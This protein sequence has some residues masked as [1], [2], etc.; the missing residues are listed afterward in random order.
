MAISP[1]S[2]WCIRSGRGPVA[3][4]CFLGP[5][6]TPESEHSGPSWAFQ[7]SDWPPLRGHIFHLASQSTEMRSVLD[8]FATAQSICGGSLQSVQLNGAHS[9]HSSCW[10]RRHARILTLQDKVESLIARRDQ[11]SMFSTTLWGKSPFEVAGNVIGRLK[12]TS[13]WTGSESECRV[14]VCVGVLLGCSPSAV[15]N[16]YTLCVPSRPARVRT[17]KTKLSA[18]WWELLLR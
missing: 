1:S 13:S 16:T 12:D 4:W 11:R 14:A 15:K 8:F 7:G 18:S 5:A 3:Y 2:W 6:S 9:S 17:F 10:P